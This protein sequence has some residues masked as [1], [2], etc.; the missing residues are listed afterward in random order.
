MEYLIFVEDVQISHKTFLLTV[1][2]YIAKSFLKQNTQLHLQ[3]LYL[4]K[5]HT[6]FDPTLHHL[7]YM[8]VQVSVNSHR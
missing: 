2:F 3:K 7:Y 5:T 6:F 8:C 4:T 1:L